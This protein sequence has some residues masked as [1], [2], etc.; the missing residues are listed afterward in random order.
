[1]P[2]TGPR[3]EH[4]HAIS[5]LMLSVV[6]VLAVLAAAHDAGALRADRNRYA[7]YDFKSYYEWGR[8]YQRGESVWTPSL[9]DPRRKVSNYTPFFVEPFSLLIWLDAPAAHLLWQLG[10]IASLAAALWMLARNA[11]PPL[12]PAAIVA[13]ISLALL[14]R[15]LDELLFFGQ[16]SALLLLLTVTSW[17]ASRRYREMRA[18]LWLAV[19][20]LL[21]L[22]PGLLGGYYLVRRRWR[23]VAWSAF[24]STLGVVATGAGNWRNFAIYGLAHSADIAWRFVPDRISVLNLVF[25]LAGGT[26]VTA[27]SGRLMIIALTLGIDVVIVAVLVWAAARTEPDSE[28]DE[29]T[30][31]LWLAGGLLISP[32]TWHHEMPLLFPLYIATALIAGRALY[33]R[34]AET[35]WRWLLLNPGFALGAMLVAACIARE[36]VARVNHLVPRF[37]IPSIAFAGGAL[38]LRSA[39]ALKQSPRGTAE[40]MAPYID[41]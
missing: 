8:E 15:S 26:P 5:Y 11:S 14:S 22:Y 10:E 23:I 3:R 6:T 17:A 13:V 30:F 4:N 38:V 12:A 28:L 41:T 24:F 21:K 33:G 2:S 32:M 40:S 20:A 7:Q 19:V 35:G 36:F 1:M 29:L 31:G 27:S 16:N 34:S 9:A 37:L 39:L 25:R 18:G